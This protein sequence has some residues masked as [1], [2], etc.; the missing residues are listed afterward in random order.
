VAELGQRALAGL[1]LDELIQDAAACAA[2]ELRT[3]FASVLEL[4]GDGLGLVIR[5]GCGLPDGVIGGVVPTRRE[6]LP[7]FALEHDGPVIV[8]DFRT[9]SRF[10]ASPIQR[11]LGVVSALV[12][13]IRTS[14][15]QFGGI[16]VHSRKPH[17]FSADDATSCSRSR[18]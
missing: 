16:G 18:T 14:A 17:H 1:D 7:G 15:G 5:A 8:D 10:S 11:D 12:A 3:E 9:E 6:H 13:Q 4:T 2:R